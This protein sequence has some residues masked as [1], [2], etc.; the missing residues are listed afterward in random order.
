MKHS[1]SPKVRRQSLAEQQQKYRATRQMDQPKKRQTNNSK[2]DDYQSITDNY[3]QKK[4][5]KTVTMIMIFK[6]KIFIIQRIIMLMRMKMKLRVMILN[7]L[8]RHLP[9]RKRH[10]S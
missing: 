1:Y 8:N 2:N 7:L 9:L 5:K 10:L 6:K 4:S 3:G